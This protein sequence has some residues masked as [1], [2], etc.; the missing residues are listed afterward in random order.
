MIKMAAEHTPCYYE[1]SK[2][3]CYLSLIVI[4]G[5]PQCEEKES[6]PSA[7]LLG[8]TCHK[9]STTL[10]CL[11]QGFFYKWP[12]NVTWKRNGQE[13]PRLAVA[14]EEAKEEGK[15][16]FGI[17]SRLTVATAEWRE[18]YTYS[19]HVSQGDIGAEAEITSEHSQQQSFSGI[20]Q[21]L[22]I[23]Q[24]IFLLLAVKSFAYGTILGIYTVCRKT[25]L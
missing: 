11:A 12:L 7:L 8:P 22:R 19:C 14:T 18:G 21:S 17:A 4:S 9:K 15:C 23:G 25:G 6:S 10:V 24:L 5:D 16:N 2:L 20:G 13:V 1:L 3:Q